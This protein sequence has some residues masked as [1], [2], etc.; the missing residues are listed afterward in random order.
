MYVYVFLCPMVL[1]A[2]VVLG[3][4]CMVVFTL[5]FGAVPFVLEGVA[6]SWTFTVLGFLYG[7]GS[8]LAEMGSYAMVTQVR[9]VISRHVTSSQAKSS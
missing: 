9:H 4:G 8:T 1:Q 5:A 7:C 6:A 3:L 2:T